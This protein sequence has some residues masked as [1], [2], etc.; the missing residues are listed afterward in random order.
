MKCTS[1]GK[2]IGCHFVVDERSVKSIGCGCDPKLDL[3]T[4]RS[5]E[6]L[7]RIWVDSMGRTIKSV[8]GDK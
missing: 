4:E 7:E 6:F 5:V 1:C 2:P 3:I 8:R